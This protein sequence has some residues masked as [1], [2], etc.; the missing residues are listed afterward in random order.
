M[1]LKEILYKVALETVH[2]TTDVAV[3]NIHFDSRKI[4]YVKNWK[5]QQTKR[6]NQ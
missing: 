2:G 4:D 5:D 1:L 3:N 6:R